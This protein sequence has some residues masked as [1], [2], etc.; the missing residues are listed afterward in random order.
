MTERLASILGALP[1]H[2]ERVWVSIP[3]FACAGLLRDARGA[4][5][6]FQMHMAAHFFANA[7]AAC[8]F[9]NALVAQMPIACSHFLFRCGVDGWSAEWSSVQLDS[10]NF[11]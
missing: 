8:L 2:L 1:D 6:S 11:S 5:S 7:L 3:S 9:M 4:F 10:D